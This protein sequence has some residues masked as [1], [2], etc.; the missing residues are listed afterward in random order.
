[1]LTR[2]ACGSAGR[3][4][5]AEAID[6]WQGV[7]D[8]RMGFRDGQFQVSPLIVLSLSSHFTG[9]NARTRSDRQ[10]RCACI[11]QQVLRVHGSTS[12][13]PRVYTCC[14]REAVD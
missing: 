8:I 10:A 1:M 5:I 9:T 4:D 11:G 2:V 7:A 3:Q 13:S 14:Q 12:L 6:E